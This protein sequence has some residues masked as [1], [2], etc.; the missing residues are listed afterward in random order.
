MVTLKTL[1]VTTLEIGSR[2]GD[3][4]KL[5]KYDVIVRVDYTWVNEYGDERKNWVTNIGQ[6]RSTDPDSLPEWIAAN[7]IKFDP[8][9]TEKVAQVLFSEISCY[10]IT[11][12]K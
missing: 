12:V 5:K 9:G 4:P 8:P 3:M 2:L 7:E 11:E 6:Y 10:T 1:T